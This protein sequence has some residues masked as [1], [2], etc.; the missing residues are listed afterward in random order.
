MKVRKIEDIEKDKLNAKLEDSIFLRVIDFGLGY[1]DGFTFDQV[2]KGLELKGWEQKTVEEYFY[3]A[4][5]NDNSKRGVNPGGSVETPFFLIKRGGGNYQ[6][7]TYR[8]IVSYDAN[9]KFI[10]YHELKFARE[11]AK[12]ARSLATIAIAV[13]VGAALASIF[14]PIFVAQWFTQNVRLDNDQL[15]NL[16]QALVSTTTPI[17][18]PY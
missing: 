8:Y 7:D 4:Y 1:P 11:N 15:R 10:D 5:S 2:M 14:M 18:N 16:Q 12:E 6:D 3:N 17:S 9:F 13:S